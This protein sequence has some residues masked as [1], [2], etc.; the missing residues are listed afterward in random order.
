M[1][2]IITKL[3][4]SAVESTAAVEVSQ[5]PQERSEHPPQRWHAQYGVVAGAVDIFDGN[6]GWLRIKVV[7]VDVGQR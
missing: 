7:V 5:P 4:N 6:H 2:F 1:K 3:T